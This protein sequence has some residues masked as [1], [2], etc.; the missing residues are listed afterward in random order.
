MFWVGSPCLFGIGGKFGGASFVGLLCTS[1]ARGGGAGCVGDC[2]LGGVG[3]VG[4]CLGGGDGCM[5]DC[6]F[7]ESFGES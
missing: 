4:D 7:G 2:L 1:F 3:F 6:C 5:G